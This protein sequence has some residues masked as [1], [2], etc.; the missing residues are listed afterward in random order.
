MNLHS[1]V[2]VFILFF[3]HSFYFS[4]SQQ[5]AV[6]IGVVRDAS[7]KEKL[8]GVTIT[9]DNISGTA[10]DATGRYELKTTQGNHNLTFN[11]IG[12]KTVSRNIVLDSLAAKILNID[13][14]SSS[15]ELGTVVVT[16]SKFEQRLE[17]VT[18]SMAV[19]KPGFLQNTNT[20]DMDIGINQVP[21]VTVIDGQANI[22]GGSGFSYGAGSRVLVLVDDMPMITADAG[23]V[24][25]SFL[26]VENL[27]QVEVI[28]GAASALYGSSAMNGIINIR[29]AYPKSEPE[30]KII[31]FAGHYD[32]PKRKAYKWW[33]G[34]NQTFNGYNFSHSRKIGRFDLVAAGNVFRDDGFRQGEFKQY[35]R[36]NINTRYSFKNTFDGLSLGI[37]GNIQRNKGGLFTIWQDDSTGAYLPLGGLDT[38]TTS[39]SEYVTIRKKMDPF[40]TYVSKHGSSY[41][42]RGR[43]FSSD[44]I[45]NTQQ[46][47]S[48]ETYFGEAQ[49]QKSIKEW[50]L[51]VTGGF[52]YTYNKVKGE[53]Y[54]D[55][56]S[57]NTAVYAQFDKTFI[58]RINFSIG[59]RLESNKIDSGKVESKP[60][61]R[62]GINI[63]VFENTHVRASYGQGYRFPSVAEKFIR[64]E[65]GNRFEVFPNDSLQSET[66]WSAEGA[67]NQGFKISD[68]KGSIDV[69]Y[70]WME[71]RDMMEFSFGQYGKIVPPTYGIGFK[72]LNTGNT[73][74]NGVDVTLSGQ[75][76]LGNVP[77]T[78]LC[79]YTYIDPIQLDFDPKKD[80]VFNSVTYNVLKYRYR[81]MFKG[82]VEATFFSRIV[83]GVSVRYTSFMENID[84]AFNSYIPG[85]KHYRDIHKV[86]D[87]V[88]DNR[89]IFKLTD[90]IDLGLITKNVFNHEYMGR[91][92][93]LQPPRSFTMQARIKF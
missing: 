90:Q 17:D 42:L 69:A 27:E 57:K 72:S 79:G 70:F 30:T 59:G 8:A 50:G 21:G 38:A 74:I 78:L 31:M 9:V 62:S 41:K 29:T 87:W 93:D 68:W 45:N 33:N 53:L 25:W 91:P 89:I 36:A 86:D 26:P 92:A 58:K 12:Y 2:A 15:T 19:L 64:T 82:D 85:L 51:T 23:D 60:V 37:N 81:R 10:T 28:K 65:I 48:A 34:N 13:L 14:I 22:R 61:F 71:Y 18:V 67:I 49:Y 88:F 84:K 80:T 76:K 83:F 3:I 4:F 35:Y 11:F 52:A 1:K 39:I 7:S 77:M 63:K 44:N 73:R 66:G 16:A 54:N 75:G 43:Y 24:K 32:S 5:E 6:V 56:K 47:S 20:T 40:I 55:H 46:Q